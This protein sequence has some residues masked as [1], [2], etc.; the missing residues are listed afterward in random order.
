LLSV[1]LLHYDCTHTY[2]RIFTYQ[3][4]LLMDQAF[5]GSRASI[6]LYLPEKKSVHTMA[7]V[8]VPLSPFSISGLMNLP[9]VVA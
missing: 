2:P 8:L 7:G 6:C 4:S 3:P 1:L 9:V 5:I